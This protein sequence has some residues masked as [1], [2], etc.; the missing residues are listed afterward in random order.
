MRILAL[1]VATAAAVSFAYFRLLRPWHSRWGASEV[2]VDKPLPG[3]ELIT[4]P[5]FQSTRAITIHAPPEDVW[6][7]LVQI[8]YG[9][10]GFYSYD[11]LENA[12]TRLFG[13]D[14]H[15]KSI[16]EI[17]PELQTLRVD[18][19]VPAAPQKQQDGEQANKI[20]W[21]VKRLESPRLM[22]LENW[23]SFVLEPAEG[24]RTRLIVRTRGG[25]TRKDAAAY[26]PWELPHFIMERKMLY[27]IKERAER[28]AAKKRQPGNVM[29]TVS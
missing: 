28:L 23:G 17:R 20:G 1:F 2:E 6:P 12:F 29:Q 27:G 5:R 16:D 18:D 21:T 14:A 9:R 15:Y 13:L 19:F 3:D 11:V 8:G 26:L 22:V 24:G 4:E 7:W 25:R 10:G